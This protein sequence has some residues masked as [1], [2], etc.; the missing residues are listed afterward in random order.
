MSDQNFRYEKEFDLSKYI[1]KYFERGFIIRHGQ[2]IFTQVLV[3]LTGKIIY[4]NRKVLL[5][6]QLQKRKEM[7]KKENWR[8][9]IRKKPNFVEKKGLFAQKDNANPNQA[10]T[11]RMVTSEKKKILIKRSWPEFDDSILDDFFM[12]REKNSKQS[13]ENTKKTSKLFLSKATKK[14]IN[15]ILGINEQVEFYSHKRRLPNEI[16]GNKIV[17]SRYLHC[18]HE[19]VYRSVCTECFCLIS[20]MEPHR[21]AT[22][23]KCRQV[24]GSLKSLE[25]KT[26]LFEQRKLVLVLGLEGTLVHSQFL[27]LSSKCLFNLTE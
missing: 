23:E 17:W 15:Q 22:R 2:E 7:E 1:P 27:D 11:E 25:F 21:S 10:E 24:R 19:L 14:E 20:D 16:L 3:P 5:E 13:T 8:N 6:Q 4:I 26:R 18:R 12:N 9:R